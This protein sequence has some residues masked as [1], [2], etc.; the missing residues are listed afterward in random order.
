MLNKEISNDKLSRIKLLILDSDGVVIPRGTKIREGE[1]GEKYFANI[2]TYKISD[3]LAEKINRL[4]SKIK[5]CIS[6]GR[7][8]IY[9]QSMYAAIIGEGVILQAENGNLSLIGGQIMQHFDYG[10]DYF[11]KI[12]AIRNEIVR[13]E[14][15]SMASIL[16]FEPKQFILTI[17][18]KDEARGVYDIVK[19]HDYDE[20][21]KI[22]WNGEAFDIQKH[23]ISKGEGLRRLLG[24][25]NI[26]S[27]EV[28]AMGD[29]IN[30]KELLEVAGRGVSADKDA[31]PA[32]YWTVGEG[33]PGEALVD[34][35]LERLLV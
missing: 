26:K 24:F 9:I 19:K 4:K 14:E 32:E 21:L 15:E 30:D 27:E 22:M 6:S 17:H 25:L 12:A 7:S 29:R 34:Y 8:L 1:T 3:R 23:S 2:E 31:L 5:V 16:G 28:I 35:L 13:S 18:S 20:E 10:E 33:L 11:K